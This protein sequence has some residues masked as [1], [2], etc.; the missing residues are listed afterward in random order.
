MRKL[1]PRIVLTILVAAGAA[2]AVISTTRD[3]DQRAAEASTVSSPI[4]D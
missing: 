4:I 2:F 3:E 1:V